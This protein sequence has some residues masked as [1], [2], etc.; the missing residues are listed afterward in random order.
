MYYLYSIISAGYSLQIL[1]PSICCECHR[2]SLCTPSLDYTLFYYMPCVYARSCELWRVSAPWGIGFSGVTV[3]VK[4]EYVP[5]RYGV[6]SSFVPPPVAVSFFHFLDVKNSLQYLRNSL[7][8]SVLYQHHA[9]MCA[10]LISRH[11]FGLCVLELKPCS[12]ILAN[13]KTTRTAVQV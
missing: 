12:L 11:V 7:N 6:P 10:F 1:R 2:N 3:F 9:G 8:I 5:G 4:H 13:V